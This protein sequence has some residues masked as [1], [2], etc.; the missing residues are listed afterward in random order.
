MCGFVLAYAQTADSLPDQDLLDRM[1]GAIRHRGPDGH[2][3]QRSERAV[4]GHR[5]LAIIDLAGGQQPMCAPDG[6]SWIVFNGEIY[7]FDAVRDELAAAGHPLDTRSDTEVL[8]H[9]YLAWGER[10]LDRINGMFAFAIYD[11]RTQTLFAARDRFGEKPLY[12][13][14]SNGTLYLASELKALVAAGLVEKRLD[15][16]ALYNYFANSY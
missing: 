12:V 10:C 14:E 8:L 2:G 5:R 15:P 4:T 16:V 9:A 11:G 3:Q 6:R 1:D 13:M 7:N